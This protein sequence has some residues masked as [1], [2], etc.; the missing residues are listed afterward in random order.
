MRVALKEW[1]NGRKSERKWFS[2]L[3]VGIVELEVVS[4]CGSGSK[5]TFAGQIGKVH[6]ER[7][8]SNRDLI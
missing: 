4:K 3:D 1:K 6:L 5:W 8:L 7:N 2:F